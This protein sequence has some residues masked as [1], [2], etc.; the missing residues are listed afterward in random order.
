MII[1]NKEKITEDILFTND[2][3]ELN[4][5]FFS[6]KKLL[7][8]SKEKLRIESIK[9]V[10]ELI[11]HDI[12]SPLSAVNAILNEKDIV[13]ERKILLKKIF[14]RIND[15]M[16]NLSNVNGIKSENNEL[17][18]YPSFIPFLV[19]SIIE[20]KKIEVVD[21]DIDFIIS[22]KD[23]LFSAINPGEFKRAI[24]NLLNNA[25]ESVSDNRKII[26]S[27]FSN[28]GNILIKIK[29]NG[30][31]FNDDVLKKLGNEKITFGKKEGKGIGLFSSIHLFQLWH[32]NLTVE[33]N[34]GSE[35]ATVTITL[36]LVN[37][38]EWF[39]DKI[40]INENISIVV[41]DDDVS[42]YEVWN[43][44]FKENNYFNEV[45]YFYTLKNFENWLFEDRKK[46]KNYL[47]LIDYEIEGSEKN[48]LDV[49]EQFGLQEFSIL[50]TNRAN[51]L[52]IQEKCML[53]SIK[54]LPKSIL[55]KIEIIMQ[56][57]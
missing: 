56:D 47:F 57:T 43:N 14:K 28:N 34:V 51:E 36:P 26:I 41:I 25:I 29:D 48:G 7:L 21:L 42:I 35:G 11:S 15:I 2:T 9:D 13:E 6:I 44:I 24:S 55:G 45:I 17:N 37:P 53:H 32:G 23:S 38:P 33:N 10:V 46:L 19:N 1:L 3:V 30:T 16:D 54:L 12:R 5:I 50:V 4:Q 52:K 22:N 20:E 39:V 18:I 8:D 31:G 49:I 40:F 27:I